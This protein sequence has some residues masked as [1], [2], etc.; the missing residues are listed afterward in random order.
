MLVSCRITDIG[1]KASILGGDGH[2][3]RLRWKEVRCTVTALIWR[4]I[5]ESISNRLSVPMSM[6]ERDA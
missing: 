6:E 4:F 1:L 2:K 5:D 3:G